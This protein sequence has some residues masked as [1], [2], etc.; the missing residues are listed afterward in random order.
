MSVGMTAVHWVLRHLSSP[1]IVG[2]TA[3]V[4]DCPDAVC[5]VKS[6]DT[7]EQNAHRHTPMRTCDAL[8]AASD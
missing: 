3:P 5:L 7:D 4:S 2:V 8:T 1:V 6:T